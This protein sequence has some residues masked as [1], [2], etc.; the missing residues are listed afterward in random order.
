MRKTFGSRFVKMIGFSMVILV[1][2]AAVKIL[3][4]RNEICKKIY[5]NGIAQWSEA[6]KV[7]I[8]IQYFSDLFKSSN[9]EDYFSM[10]RGLPPRVTHR[11][12]HHLIR[13]VTPEEIK[14]V[15]SQ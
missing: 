1:F 3:R 4:A 2:H 11:M 5:K 12:N 10:R 15:F 13:K 6:S 8:A 14:E 9:S 7:R